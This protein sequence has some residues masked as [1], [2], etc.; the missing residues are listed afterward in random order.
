[1][2]GHANPKMWR[3]MSKLQIIEQVFDLPKTITSIMDNPYL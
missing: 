1:M 2:M 3:F